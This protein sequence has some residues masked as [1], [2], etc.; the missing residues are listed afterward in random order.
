MV[1]GESDFVM[2]DL[3]QNVV[4]TAKAIASLIYRYPYQTA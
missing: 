2:N 4:I 3:H 1:D